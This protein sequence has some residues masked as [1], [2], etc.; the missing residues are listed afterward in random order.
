VQ[1]CSLCAVCEHACPTGAIQRESIDFREC[2]RCNACEVKLVHHAGV[3]RHD[4][5]KVA[6]LLQLKRGRPKPSLRPGAVGGD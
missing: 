5:D 1:Q 4:V 6:H 3:C 2:V